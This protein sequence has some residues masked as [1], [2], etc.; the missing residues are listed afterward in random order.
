LA[1][2]SE[3]EMH[4]YIVLVHLQIQLLRSDTKP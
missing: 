1:N 3:T 2:K 4:I